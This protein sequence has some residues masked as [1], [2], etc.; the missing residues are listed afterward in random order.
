MRGAIVQGEPQGGVAGSSRE[1]VAYLINQYPKGS[2]TFI[3]R[4][5]VGLEAQGVVVD[6]FS[7]RPLEGRLADARDLEERER[8]FVLLDEGPLAFAVA[9]LRRALAG[10]LSFLGAL[11]LAARTGWRSERGLLVHFIYLAEACLLLAELRRR[12]ATHLHAHFGTNPATVAMLCR[13]LGGPPYSFTVHGPEEFDKPT[14]IA[15]P[16]K[17]ERAE[18]VAS[19]SSFGRSQLYRQVRLDHWSKVKI[20]RCGVDRA[21]LEAPLTPVPAAPRLACV[22]RLCEQK[23]QLL[24][25][26]AAGRLARDGVDFTLALVGDGELREEIEER[27]A[28]LSLERHVHITGWASGERVKEEL[29]AARAMVLPSFA[30]GLPVVIMEA[31]AL[32]RP[33]LS[34]YVAGIPELVVPGES[35]WL[36][37]AGSIGALVEAMRE[38][39]AAPTHV[40]DRMGRAG[41]ARVLGL[42]DA[43]A[44]ARDLSGLFRDSVRREE[45]RRLKRAA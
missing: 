21:F 33:V 37:P 13:A 11:A 23:G 17:I 2:H 4:E 45:T 14:F 26:E 44:I 5:I 6:R 40:L 30:E 43:D 27:I 39:L 19:V 25:V 38:A 7:I 31:L 34:T 15:L 28:T 18:F 22:G 41:R 16:E 20:V 1:R 10:P 35:G 8:T 12:G 29:L 42:H 24:L 3:R 36:V 9:A 32:G